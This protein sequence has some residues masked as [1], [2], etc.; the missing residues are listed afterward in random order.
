MGS[1]TSA[2]PDSTSNNDFLP[3]HM[4]SSPMLKGLA[5]G[6]S[7]KGSPFQLR[8]SMQR[9]TNTVITSLNLK[10]EAHAQDHDILP[11]QIMQKQNERSSSYLV[12]GAFET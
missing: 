8:M 12:G 3:K 9:D 10:M 1:G 7:P 2:H 4:T 6:Y 11:S 5:F